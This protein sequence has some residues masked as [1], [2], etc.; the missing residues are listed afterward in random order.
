MTGTDLPLSS[1]EHPR[2]RLLGVM[3]PIAARVMRLRWP[4]TVH[5][6][7]LVPAEGGVIL[8][9]N[10]IGLVDGPMLA[11]YAPRPVHALT[12]QEMFDGFVGAFLR[13]TGQIPL[14]RR[15]ADPAA[16]RTGLRVVRDGGVLGIFPEGTRGNGDL[17]RFHHGA[18][19]L[20]L[21]TGAPVVPVTFFGT[22]VGDGSKALPASGGDID[23]VFGRPWR[24]TQQP[25]PRTREHVAATSVLLRGHM[26]SELD[27]ALAQTRR[28]LPE[29]L[30]AGQSDDDP[31]TG[32][33]EP[34]TEL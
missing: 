10:H 23:I 5:R 9:A 33:V 18:A 26:L 17:W 24:T 34:S 32:L 20:A 2:T 28:S 4:V 15:A 16:I 6:A 8:A 19:Y 22:R 21:V 14:D 31:D 30:R 27:S 12:K 11:T 1:A 29:P 25:W 7:E 3:R 13:G